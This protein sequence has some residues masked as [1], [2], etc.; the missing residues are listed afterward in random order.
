M[1]HAAASLSPLS[2]HAQLVITYIWAGAG[3]IFVDGEFTAD[4][5]GTLVGHGG[6]DAAFMASSK[7]PAG[8]EAGSVSEHQRCRMA[9]QA[10]AHC[11]NAAS[12][13][14][15]ASGSAVSICSRGPV[16]ITSLARVRTIPLA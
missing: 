2:L 12:I 8:F 5:A 1:D 14:A 6:G 4:Q 9:L 13:T 11:V 3:K 7:I 15:L 10:P 16:P